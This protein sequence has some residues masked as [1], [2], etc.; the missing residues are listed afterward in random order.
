M[1]VINDAT[2]AI[3][4][5]PI[6]FWSINNTMYLTQTDCVL[7]CASQKSIAKNSCKVCISRLKSASIS[8]VLS[9]SMYLILY[10]N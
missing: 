9:K 6:M 1:V 7:S 8:V 4:A 3:H 10:A 5:L 2:A